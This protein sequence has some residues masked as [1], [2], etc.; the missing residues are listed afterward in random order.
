MV[1][2]HVVSVPQTFT[3]ANGADGSAVAAVDL[4]AS[5][6]IILIQCTDCS[7]VAAS[8]NLTALVGYTAADTLSDLYEQ[9][10]PS[11]QWS[12]GDLPTTG[13]LAFILT[14]ATGARRLRLVL[15]NNASGGSVVFTVYGLD[16]GV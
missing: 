9:D 4:G 3:I 7:N 16:K 12:K 10:D 11:T 1:M 13:T 15:S 2:E 5:Y 14:H 6:K 8:T